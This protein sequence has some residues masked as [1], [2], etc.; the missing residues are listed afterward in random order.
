MMVGAGGA[1]EE[2]DQEGDLLADSYLGE[3]LSRSVSV[4]RNL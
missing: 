4:T 3:A 1:L 2:G